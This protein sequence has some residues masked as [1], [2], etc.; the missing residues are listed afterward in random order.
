VVSDAYTMLLDSGNDILDIHNWIIPTFRY[1]LFAH[2]LADFQF[3]TR[4]IEYLETL[5]KGGQKSR[6]L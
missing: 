2:S 1:G 4:H 5:P 6:T 3:S